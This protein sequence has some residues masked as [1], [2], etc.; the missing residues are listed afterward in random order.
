VVGLGPVVAVIPMAALVAVMILV[1]V[2]TFNWHSIQPATLRRMPRSETTVMIVTVVVVV[3]SHNLAYGVFSGVLAASILFARR[4]AHLVDVSSVLDPDGSTRIYSVHG[5]VFFASSNDLVYRFDMTN[6]HVWDA[7]SV[8]AMD[9][10]TT[11][12]QARGK[13]VQIIGLNAAS[14]RMHAQLAG[15]LGAGH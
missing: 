5:E 10:I 14:A 7:S 13:Q 3:V 1:A 12:Y 11:K 15:Q 2:S 6:A 4:V 9:A 8:A